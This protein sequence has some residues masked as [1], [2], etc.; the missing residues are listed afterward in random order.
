MKKYKINLGSCGGRSISTSIILANDEHEAVVKYLES[1]EE[2]ITEE[3]IETY[4]KGVYEHVPKPRK[5]DEI[6]PL[7][8]ENV[9]ELERICE[10]VIDIEE[11]LMFGTILFRYD[12]L[13][14]AMKPGHPMEILDSILANIY[15]TVSGGKEPSMAKMK[16]TLKDFKGF[17]SAFD[18]KE[19]SKPIKELSD[20]IKARELGMADKASKTKG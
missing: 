1:I 14:S 2:E 11:G 12:N 20:Y 18:V 3:K 13:M 10:E 19:M 15:F 7:K 17:K 8:R 6:K 9:K 5:K 4:L 16:E